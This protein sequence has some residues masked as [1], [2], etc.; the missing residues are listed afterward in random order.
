MICAVDRKSMNY[1]LHLAAHSFEID[2]V[3]AE[4]SAAL[5]DASLPNV[6]LKGP[7]IA[8]WLYPGEEPRLYGDTDLLVRRKDWEQ[9]ME[10]V[11]GLGFKDDLG[12]LEHP[13]METGAGY[14]Y[15]RDSDGAGVDLHY[16]L[17]GVGAAPEALWDAFIETS[18]LE[19]VGGRRIP[20]PSRPAR[21][22]HIA[23][24]AVQH[25][26]EAWEKPMRDLEQGIAKAGKSEWEDALRLA[27]RLDAATTFSTGLRLLPQ[28]RQ[29]AEEIGAKYAESSKDVLRLGQVP[30]AEGFQ[31]LASTPGLA[32]KAKIIL[33]EMV[34]SA[35]FMRWWSP[36]ARRGAVGLALTYCWRPIWLFMH[37]AP[38]FRA[39]RSANRRS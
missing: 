18:V 6:L 26:G 21:L 15:A 11:E 33:R 34:P 17:F 8:T 28:G 3:T 22:M 24:H 39:W 4:V 25:G 9:V 2:K 27:E 10:V 5:D 32:A 19:P 20:L 30:M 14:P 23:L 1:S 29:L 38:G 12:P 36:L 37:A 13:R 16:T 35:E 7:G 31:E